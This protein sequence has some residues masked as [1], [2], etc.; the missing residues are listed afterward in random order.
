MCDE[1]IVEHRERSDECSEDEKECVFVITLEK[2]FIRKDKSRQEKNEDERG[3]PEGDIDMKSEA[4]N[5]PR[6]KEISE[7]SRT[8]ASE[9][10]IEG[11]SQNKGR[12]DCPKSDTGKID[13]P[14]GGRNHKGSK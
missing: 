13:G 12:H 1:K 4:E 8:E 5:D 3:N 7:L 14:I 9:E 10:E 2:V 6:K 11:E